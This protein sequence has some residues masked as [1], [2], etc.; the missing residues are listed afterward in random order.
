MAGQVGIGAQSVASFAAQLQHV[1]FARKKI[2]L[3]ARPDAIEIPFLPVHE[4]LVELI[5]V[6]AGVVGV[7]GPHL[8]IVPSKAG[9]V[10]GTAGADLADHDLAAFGHRAQRPHAI[11]FHGRVRYGLVGMD[12]SFDL[13]LAG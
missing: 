11:D 6:I 8:L 13:R 10:D 9:Q 3:R 12:V 4:E 7:F 2:V 1:E 5:A